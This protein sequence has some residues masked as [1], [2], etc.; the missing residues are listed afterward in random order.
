VSALAVLLGVGGGMALPMTAEAAGSDPTPV[1]PAEGAFVEDSTVVLE[2]TTSDAPLGY[3]VSWSST[4]V[5]DESGLVSTSEPTT[6]IE[7][8]GGSYTW[9]VRALPEGAWSAP[10]TF[11]VDVELP[12]L[13]LPEDAGAVPAEAAA[14]P[15]GIE[16]VPGSVWIL[17]A[18]A[19]AAVFL[20]VVVVQSR[21]HREQDA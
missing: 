13:A 17:G 9:Q 5:A 6:T 11:H 12:T 2:W 8:D 20:A 21:L 15:S 19:F 16:Q 3:E 10:A 1:A 4:D 18:L 7:V 14:R